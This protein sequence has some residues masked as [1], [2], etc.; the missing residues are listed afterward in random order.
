[1]SAYYGNKVMKEF[2]EKSVLFDS[3][4]FSILTATMKGCE[5][6]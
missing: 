6:C 2:K 4:P 3:F 1:M 5:A